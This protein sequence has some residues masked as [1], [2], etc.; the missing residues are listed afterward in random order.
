M[1]AHELA[2]ILANI[3]L[4][5]ADDREILVARVR[6]DRDNTSGV[7]DCEWSLRAICDELDCDMDTAE[8]V[9]AAYAGALREVCDV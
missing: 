8:K 2:L 5:C 3:D 9:H 7:L 4:N 6:A 1:N